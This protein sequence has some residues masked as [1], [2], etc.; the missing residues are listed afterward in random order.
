[1]TTVKILD[2]AGKDILKNHSWKPYGGVACEFVGVHAKEGETVVIKEYAA[3]TSGNYCSN[4]RTEAESVL[5][6]VMQQGFAQELVE[7]TKAYDE[8]WRMGD[9]SGIPSCLSFLSLTLCFQRWLEIWALA[10][11]MERDR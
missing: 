5:R 2:C 4:V 6:E 7:H 10:A 11:G 3:V 8:L 9:P 1:M